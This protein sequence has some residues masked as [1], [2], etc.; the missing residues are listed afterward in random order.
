MDSECEKDRHHYLETLRALRLLQGFIRRRRWRKMLQVKTLPIVHG[1]FGM[2]AWPIFRGPDLVGVEGP[3]GHQYRGLSLGFLSVSNPIRHFIIFLVESPWFD[4]LSLVLVTVNCLLLAE[5]G[6]PN[7]HDGALLRFEQEADLAFTLVF[8]LELLC[9]IAARGFSG[10]EHSYLAGGWNQLDLV[11]VGSSWLPLLLPQL[12]SF[13]GVRAIRALRPLRTIHRLPGLRRQ[14]VTLIESLNYLADVAMLSFFLMVIFG[15]LGLQLFKG[16]L[17]S[18]CYL[19]GSSTPIDGPV[20]TSP[21]GVCAR[22]DDTDSLQG[23]C[24]AG[25]ECRLYGLNPEQGTISFDTIDA[26][27]ITIFRCITLEGWTTVYF[28]TSRAANPYVAGTYFISVVSLGTFYLLNLFLAVMWHTYTK[29]L[30]DEQALRPARVKLWKGGGDESVAPAELTGLMQVRAEVRRHVESSAFQV[31]TVGLII[32][33]VALMMCE[34]YPEDPERHAVLES[35]NVALSLLFTLEML[36]KHIALGVRGYWSDS[37]NRLDGAVVVTSLLEFAH[38]LLDLG[39]VHGQVLR[40][41][42]LLRVFKFLR[43][44]KPLQR[45]LNA[46][47]GSMQ[48]FAYLMLLLALILFIFALLGMQLFGGRFVPPLFDDMP[49]ENFDSIASAMIT[50]F[51]V[52]VGDGWTPIWVNTQIAVGEWATLFFILLIVIAS[53]VLLNLV[54]ALLVASFETAAQAEEEPPAP[55]SAEARVAAAGADSTQAYSL[56]AFDAAPLAMQGG[57]APSP[58]R[59]HSDAP[60]SHHMIDGT[61]PPMPSDIEAANTPTP[62]RAVEDDDLALGSMPPTHPV[63]MLASRLVAWRIEGTPISFENAVIALIITSSADLAFRSCAVDMESEYYATLEHFDV[64]ATG[65]FTVE[66][67]AKIVSL[68]FISTPNA[69]LKT[70]WNQLDCFIVTASLLSDSSPA[71]RTLRVL[72]VLRPLRLISRHEGMRLVVTLLMRALPGV[73]D[74]LLVYVLFLIVF[75][76]LGVQIFA[77]KLYSCPRDLSLQTEAACTA[78]GHAWTNPYLGSFDNVFSSSLLLFEVSSLEG[79]TD[80]LFAGIDASDVGVAPR[81]DATPAHALFFIAW[82]V[83]G[84]FCL[85]NLLVGVLVSTYADIKRRSEDD[86]G[87]LSTKQRQWVAMIARFLEYTPKPRHPPPTQA[88][89]RPCYNLAVLWPHFD[90]TIL[91]VVLFNTVLLALDAEGITPLQQTILSQLNAICTFIFVCE[92][93]VKIIAIGCANYVSEPWNVFDAIIVTFA[94]ADWVISLEAAVAGNNP[95]VVRALRLVRIMRVLRTIRVVKSVRGLKMLL[96]MLLISLPGLVNVLGIFLILLVMYSLLGMQL[97]GRVAF[98]EHITTEA[99]FCEFPTA[100]FTMMRSATGEEWNGLMHDAMVAPDSGLC[101]AEAGNCGSP[102]AVPF[103]VS[104]V[105]LTTFIVLKM[106]VALILEGFF[107]ALQRDSH[108]LDLEH[109]EVFVDRWSH[110][111]PEA[112]GWMPARFLV[113]LLRQLPP[114]LGLDPQD[115]P[116]SYIRAQDYTLYAFQMHLRPKYNEATNTLEISFTEVLACLCKDA[117]LVDEADDD[118]G[119]DQS[120]KERDAFSV[121]WHAAQRRAKRREMRMKGGNDWNS[122]LPSSDVHGAKAARVIQ[123]LL[124]KDVRTTAPEEGVLAKNIATSVIASAW[125]DRALKPKMFKRQVFQAVHAKTAKDLLSLP[126]TVG[127]APPAAQPPASAAARMSTRLSSTLRFQRR[128]QDGGSK[129]GASGTAREGRSAQLLATFGEI[130]AKRPQGSKAMV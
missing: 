5:Q 122:V 68:G 20:G 75:A 19:P 1:P 107:M 121:A 43:S 125:R 65:V 66:M 84:A 101:D 32:L 78:A 113:N 123:M 31:L 129:S 127:G 8:T 83:L 12:S 55:A 51:I 50:V 17:T 61:E 24:A 109:A 124:E 14:V 111:D 30:R 130:R 29:Q 89:R 16:T 112:S 76:I 95:T 2:V 23:T 52:A 71:F 10:D 60:V 108:S 54:V 117:I 56:P 99:N 41:F 34:R 35:S 49:R 93:A 96:S 69:Y 82:I 53:Y 18:R 45:V 88:W 73:F 22:L 72:R 6:P 21:E 47:L 59:R 11:I 77:G 106:L 87:V 114:P 39:G 58:A 67:L 36:L 91:F 46:L 70:G 97:F 116:R 119:E 100:F 98:G 110:F 115:Y 9:R 128:S 64:I 62:G 90:S 92:A 7:S 28:L 103:F 118:H 80:A 105:L 25:Q 81:R 3:S 13:N 94:I 57:D 86:G 120:G 126:G 63:R 102:L 4:R 38:M 40:A 15:V 48:N 44:W 85:L 104:Y 26:A 79:W 74:V 42:R 27:W 33:N 37:F